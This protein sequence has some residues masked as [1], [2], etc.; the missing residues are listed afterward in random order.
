MRKTKLE[1]VL[2]TITTTTET[3][4]DWVECCN[5]KD[6][7][8]DEQVLKCSADGKADVYGCDECFSSESHIANHVNNEIYKIV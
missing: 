7:I 2:E 4:T 1:R 3:P 8:K 5:C 6:H